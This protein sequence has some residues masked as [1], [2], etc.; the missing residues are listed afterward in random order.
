MLNS[1]STTHS[2]QRD[3]H[4]RGLFTLQLRDYAPNNTDFD[5]L[6]SVF[7]GAMETIS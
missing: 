1:R 7:V 4:W 3:R 2:N 6:L 5:R